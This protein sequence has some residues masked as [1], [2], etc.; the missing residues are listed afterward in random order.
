V[1]EIGAA[2]FGHYPTGVAQAAWLPPGYSQRI[3]AT[4]VPGEYLG[5][6]VQGP[7][8]TQDIY[9]RIKR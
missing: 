8:G 3:T 5:V 9:Y 6:W 2:D 7:E 4:A 1:L